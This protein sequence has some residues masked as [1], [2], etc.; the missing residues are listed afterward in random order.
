MILAVDIGGTSIKYAVIENEVI[1]HK[2]YLTTP[3]GE[4]IKESIL[5]LYNSISDDYCINGITIATAGQVDVING[6]IIYAGPTIPNYTGE[7][8]KGYLFAQTKLPCEVMNDVNAALYSVDT[9]NALLIQIGT[10]IGGAYINEHEIMLGGNGQAMEIGH[11]I[12]NDNKRFEDVYSTS[13]LINRFNLF[14]GVDDFTGYKID[15]LYKEN[16]AD[17]L[18]ILEDYMMGIAKNIINLIYI[19]DPQVIYFGGGITAASFFDV[20]K[21]KSY[22]ENNIE[23]SGFLPNVETIHRGNDAG[24]YGAYKNFRRLND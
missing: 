10:G 9:S 4:E 16:C 20:G 11:V 2:G 3:G 7:D 5:D 22:I 17:T 23:N 1:L 8:L 13:A 18:F 19:L 14:F 12:I 24:L 21:I 15:Q 6:K